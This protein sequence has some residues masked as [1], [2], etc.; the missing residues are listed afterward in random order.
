MNEPVFPPGALQPPTS[1]ETNVRA[2]GADGDVICEVALLEDGT[3]LIRF[4]VLEVR[5]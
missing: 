1:P 5:K 3:H 2:Y 4:V